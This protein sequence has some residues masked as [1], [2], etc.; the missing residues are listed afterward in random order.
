MR[1]PMVPSLCA[2]ICAN[3]G[4]FVANAHI[5]LWNKVGRRQLLLLGTR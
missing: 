4:V 5:V 3:P 2:F 1:E